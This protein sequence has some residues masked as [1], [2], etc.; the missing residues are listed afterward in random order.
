MKHLCTLLLAL[1]LAANLGAQP[2]QDV[3]FY[4]FKAG[5]TQHRIN[6]I[7]IT[8]IPDVFSEETYQTEHLPRLG[9]AG[10]LVFYHRFYKSRFAVQPE[11]LFASRGGDFHY[12]DVRDLDYTVSFNYQ[13]VNLGALAKVYPAGGLHF[14]LGAQVA[15]NVSEDKL[16]YTSNMPEL[17]PDLQIQQS[18]RE[19]LVGSNDINLLGQVGYDFHF[20]LM[21]EARY[22]LGL[23]DVI[24]T[25]A[26]G[27]NFIE[28]VNRGSGFQVTLGWLI[29][30]PN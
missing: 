22:V 5:I 12:T 25:R 11:I 19:V 4:G 18:L 9:F 2:E 15:F 13:Y 27:F 24:E 17:G 8:I 14:G 30:F 23:S 26:N 3:W 10:G 16:T 21:V 6:N 29:E 7:D 28:N 20:G 1:G